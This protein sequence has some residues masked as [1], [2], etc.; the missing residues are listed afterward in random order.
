MQHLQSL[1]FA[2]RAETVRNKLKHR[3]TRGNIRQHR[4]AW[5]H[6]KK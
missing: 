5:D 1:K 3:E 6:A 2:K 4:G